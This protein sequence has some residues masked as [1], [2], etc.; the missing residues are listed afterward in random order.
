MRLPGVVLVC[1]VLLLYGRSL[2]WGFVFDDWWHL[3]RMEQYHHGERQSLGLYRFLSGGADNAQVRSLGLYPWWLGEDVRYQHFRPLAEW[4]LYAQYLFFGDRPAGF[5]AVSLALYALG[6]WIAWRVMRRV[7]GD[8]PIARWGALAYAVAGAHAVPAVFISAQC[9][10]LALVLVGCSVLAGDRFIRDGPTAGLVGCLLFFV[11][12]LGAKEVA[13]GAAA[14]PICLGMAFGDRPGAFRRAVVLTAA[15]CGA[16]VGWLYLYSHGGYGANNSPMLDP[17][18]APLDYLAALPSRALALL[19]AWLVPLNPFV[20]YVRPWGGPWLLGYL[21]VGA[22]G[23]TAVGVHFRRRHHGDRRAKGMAL[24]AAPFLPLLVC[25]PPDDR[26]M[27]LP[28][29]GLAFLGAA[30]MTRPR[31]DG[32]VRLRKVPMV[33]FLLLQAPAAL[34]VSQIMRAAESSGARLLVEAGD[35]FGR[36]QTANDCIF[37]LNVRNDFHLLFTQLWEKRQPAGA[38]PRIA[39]LS[40]VPQPRVTA[41]DDRSLLIEADKDALFSGFF[42][43]MAESRDRP[44]QEGDLFDAGEFEGRITK[45]ERGEVRAVELLFRRPLSDDAY[46]FYFIEDDGSVSRWRPATS[47]PGQ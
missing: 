44:R 11:G 30:W 37:F 19:T 34:V 22:I 21:I 5:H 38:C 20:F 36:E 3:H 7:A 2:T 16:G 28:G 26:N 43:R 18:H 39:M 40:D 35:D 29:I 10:L 25:T 45:M 13:L 17:L 32:S 46:R 33:L 14:L 9:D 24:W 8:G 6:V 31:D 27:L 1:V 41:P 12:A 4:A 15:L 42:G 47:P 23:L